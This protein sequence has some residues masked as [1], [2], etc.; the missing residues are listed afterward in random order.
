MLCKTRMQLK[1]DEQVE[2]VCVFRCR[3]QTKE[4]M[5]KRKG[6]FA[7]VRLK[8]EATRLPGSSQESL[9]DFQTFLALFRQVAMQ[10]LSLKIPN[11]D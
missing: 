1:I 9:R 11:H 10:K 6:S 3:E 4:K 2:S 8:A 5:G 7:I